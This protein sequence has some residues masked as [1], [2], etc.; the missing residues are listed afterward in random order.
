MVPWLPYH[1]WA[2]ITRLCSIESRGVAGSEGGERKGEKR[3]GGDGWE[4]GRWEGRR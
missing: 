1:P 4:G 2:A 3:S